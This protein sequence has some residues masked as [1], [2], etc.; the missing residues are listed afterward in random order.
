MDNSTTN[1]A[2]GDAPAGLLNLMR[3]AALAGL[4]LSL[5]VLS[6]TLGDGPETIAGCGGEDGGC[7]HVLQTRWS[8]WF[9]LPVSALGAGLYAGHL[10]VTYLRPRRWSLICGLSLLTVAAGTWFV[11]LQ[12]LVIGTV[13]V[14][15]MA[16]HASGLVAAVAL[17]R[18]R[19]AAVDGGAPAL[20]SAR[21]AGSTFVGILLLIVGQALSAPPETH[22]LTTAEIDGPQTSLPTEG[23]EA[24]FFDGK[25]RLDLDALPVL[26]DRNAEHVMALVFDFT[27]PS[28]RRLSRHLVQLDAR[29]DG[30]VAVVQLVCPI[31]RECNRHLRP[32][33]KERGWAC[34]L[35]RLSTALFVTDREQHDAFSDWLQR[36][37][38]EVPPTVARRKAIKLIG[39]E[40]LDA[41]LA[42]PRVDA[43]IDRGARIY[44]DL[45]AGKLPK[46]LIRGDQVIVGEVHDADGLFAVIEAE[47]GIRPVESGT[48]R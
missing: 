25:L 15:C 30:A 31:S 3:F 11:V 24:A 37:I 5:Y 41:A 36:A 19:V 39:E 27:C 26:G 43:L 12:A 40:R 35:A 32:G 4:G 29:Y 9:D 23:R 21:L 14:Y 34:D 38:T 47:L 16:T 10:A 18:A 20:P 6:V 45:G 8:L 28:C 44:S 1:A 33:V 13:C 48:P 42:D 46:L 17:W 2:I 7:A 22:A